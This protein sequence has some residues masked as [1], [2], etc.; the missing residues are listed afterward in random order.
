MMALVSAIPTLVMTVGAAVAMEL[1]RVG[2]VQL[3]VAEERSA[4]AN[5]RAAA[6]QE[7]SA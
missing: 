4:A 5:A 6:R 1:R 3:A 2:E 7:R